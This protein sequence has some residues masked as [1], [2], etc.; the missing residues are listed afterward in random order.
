MFFNVIFFYK[1]V[2]AEE[3]P[4]LPPD[5]DGENQD[6]GETN[7]EN[8]RAEMF[9][10]QEVQFQNF[11]NLIQVIEDD[12]PDYE[13]AATP[14]VRNETVFKKLNLLADPKPLSGQPGPFTSIH[15]KLEP[16][17]TQKQNPENPGNKHVHQ[18]FT[19]TFSKIT[20]EKKTNES[21]GRN[22]T[23]LPV[24][25]PGSI[26]RIKP[27][28]RTSSDSGKKYLNILDFLQ[29]TFLKN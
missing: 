22:Q 19:N 28:N 26:V 13:P 2:S 17:K 23:N 15:P 25:Q 21:K 8:A 12:V 4:V 20:A 7:P 16:A 5:Q 10:R 18:E 3:D 27:V 24:V 1:I 11:L 9:L 14:S 29:I 6:G